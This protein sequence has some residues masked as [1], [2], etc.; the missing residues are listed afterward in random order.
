MLATAG[1]RRLSVKGRGAATE[2]AEIFRRH[3]RV[4]PVEQKMVGGRIIREDTDIPIVRVAD[5]ERFCVGGQDF[6]GQ[7]RAGFERFEG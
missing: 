5:R 6:P 3:A 2:T 4:Y 7:E 1:R